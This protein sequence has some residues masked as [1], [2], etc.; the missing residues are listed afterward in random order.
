MA[1][2][3]R[4][5]LLFARLQL[6][7]PD[8]RSVLLV[9]A[10]DWSNTPALGAELARAM[11]ETGARARVLDVTGRWSGTLPDGVERME[12]LESELND[13]EHARRALQW[14]PGFTVASAG[15][16]LESPTALI[17]A[18]AVDAVLLVARQGRT[19]RNDLVQALEDIQGVGGRVVGSVLIPSAGL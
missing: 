17:L 8:A 12:V 11:V 4:A 19:M 3:V 2:A 14:L 10:R 15:G 9:S 7:A 13:L 16:V 18:A 5:D 6:R 1:D